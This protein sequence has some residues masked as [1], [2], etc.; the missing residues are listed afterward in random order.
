MKNSYPSSGEQ[1][2][3]NHEEL[4]REQTEQRDFW[5]KITVRCIMAD[6]KH[7]RPVDA[8]LAE[9]AKGQKW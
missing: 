2:R 5:R 6:L 7:G 4:H 9:W 8:E 1:R 3:S